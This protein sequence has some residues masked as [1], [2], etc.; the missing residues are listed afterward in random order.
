VL[1]AASH[2][3][4]VVNDAGGSSQ[5]QRQAPIW[6]AAGAAVADGVAPPPATANMHTSERVANINFFM[7]TS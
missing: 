4:A 1:Q 3:D 2:A 7:G 6:G 5:N